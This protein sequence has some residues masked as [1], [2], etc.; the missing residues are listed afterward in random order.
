MKKLLR[1]SLSI[2]FTLSICQSF[3]FAQFRMSKEEMDKML[4][5]KYVKPAGTRDNVTVNRPVV[6][7]HPEIKISEKAKKEITQTI[8]KM[9]DEDKYNAEFFN[10][11][12]GKFYTSLSTEGKAVYKLITEKHADKFSSADSQKLINYLESSSVSVAEKTKMGHSIVNKL[13]LVSK[14]RGLTES[15]ILKISQ[16]KYLKKKI[17]I[18]GTMFDSIIDAMYMLADYLYTGETNNAKKENTTWLCMAASGGLEN[19][20]DNVAETNAVL[21]SHLINGYAQAYNYDAA[22]QKFLIEIIES[23]TSRFVLTQAAIAL[24]YSDFSGVEISAKEFS[25]LLQAMYFCDEKIAKDIPV[26]SLD[27][28][29][30]KNQLAYAYAKASL[31]DAAFAN[32]GVFT[33][34]GKVVRTAEIKPVEGEPFLNIIF[35][36]NPLKVYMNIVLAAQTYQAGADLIRSFKAAPAKMP[37]LTGETPKE[38]LVFDMGG[39]SPVTPSGRPVVPQTSY[40]GGAGGGVAVA[41]MPKV[42]VKTQVKAPSFPAIV[43]ETAVKVTAAPSVSRPVFSANRHTNIAAGL[44]AAEKQISASAYTPSPYEL[45][46]ALSDAENGVWH[47][48]FFEKYYHLYD[49]TQRKKIDA[50]ILKS[51][52]S[53]TA[54]KSGS[55]WVKDMQIIEEYAPSIN[56]Y[57]TLKQGYVEWYYDNRILRYLSNPNYGESSETELYRG[58]MLT[59]D[60]IKYIMQHGLELKK[61]S[62]HTGSK[63]G[64]IVSFSSSENEA[65]HYIFQSGCKDGGVGVMVTVKKTADYEAL[66]DE[67]LNRTKTIY[68]AYRDIP[69]NEITGIYIWG[70]Y[71]FMPLSEIKGK[72]DEG[73]LSRKW[74]DRH[75]KNEDGS[76]GFFR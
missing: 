7:E 22:A 76:G 42:S 36:K 67:E 17:V 58:M 55:R 8:Q 73:S 64:A 60:E 57:F 29:V 53:E 26:Y 21:S 9:L 32:G 40:S 25:A 3:A 56:Q 72:I 48:G 66:V 11:A 50:I 13:A 16:G 28:Q 4:E 51:V 68:H 70:E 10:S 15:L 44:A 62:W 35:D 69:A 41:A 31:G 6:K 14:G 52:T 61:T 45:E 27:E 38:L 49:N 34:E 12:E 63:G 30:I 75:E 19:N 43:N 23:N 47:A 24:A 1:I 39:T 71:G 5:E 20:T 59:L 65:K 74:I 18:G 37:K 54:A 46:K 2:I 33:T